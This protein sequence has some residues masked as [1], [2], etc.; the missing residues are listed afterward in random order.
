MA[1]RTVKVVA[2]GRLASRIPVERTGIRVSMVLVLVVPEMLGRHTA[3]VPAIRSHR[4]PG[5]LERQQGK[6]NDREETTHAKSVA[7][8]VIGEGGPPWP[9]VAVLSIFVIR[10]TN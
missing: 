1:V 10:T 8:A 7:V 2:T 3:F 5:E 9:F 6:Q 4:S